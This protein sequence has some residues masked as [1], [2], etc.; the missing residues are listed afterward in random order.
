MVYF[1]PAE[2]LYSLRSFEVPGNQ[3]D[4]NISQPLFL[5]A[6]M[7]E[8]TDSQKVQ[9]DLPEFLEAFNNFSPTL[10]QDHECGT[11]SCPIVSDIWTESTRADLYGDLSEWA[12]PR[13]VV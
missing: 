7:R 5:G 13:L 10:S 1:L 9:L 6:E 3:R 2:S 12:I 11:M 8:W 4:D